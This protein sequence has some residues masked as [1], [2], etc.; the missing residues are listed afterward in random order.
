MID[1]HVIFD[2]IASEPQG[3]RAIPA[4]IEESEHIERNSQAHLKGCGWCEAN[5]HGDEDGSEV[6]H[7]GMQESEKIVLVNALEREYIL[8][9]D[10][11]VLQI[12]QVYLLLRRKKHIS[13]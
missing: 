7:V 10:L 8:I 13:G 12:R 11:G 4:E 5:N 2:A 9:I 6:Y 1:S 3:K